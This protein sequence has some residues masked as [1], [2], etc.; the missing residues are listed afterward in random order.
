MKKSK[1]RRKGVRDWKE[2]RAFLRALYDVNSDKAL[3]QLIAGSWVKNNRDLAETVEKL[4]DTFRR[5]GS[6]N[7]SGER[8]R[9]FWREIMKDKKL[10]TPMPKLWTSSILDFVGFFKNCNGVTL[11]VQDMLIDHRVRLTAETTARLRERHRLPSEC[12]QI[13]GQYHLTAYAPLRFEGPHT[14]VASGHIQ[15]TQFYN[16]PE[17]A[18]AW[19][20]MVDS[21]NYPVYLDCSLALKALVESSIWRDAISG[22]AYDAAVTLGG[23]ASPEKDWDLATSLFDSLNGGQQSLTYVIN[24][25]SPYMLQQSVRI[26]NRRLKKSSADARI[27]VEYHWSDFLKLGSH[28]SRPEC[29]QIVWAIF[30][31]TIGNVSESAFFNSLSGPSYAGDLLIV[32]LDTVGRDSEKEFARRMAE[33][34]R[35][36]ELD[37]LLLLPLD[38]WTN[39]ASGREPVV[40]VSISL[41]RDGDSANRSDVRKSRTAVFSMQTPN[42][43]SPS[44]VLAHSTRYVQTE[45]IR[46]AAGHGWKYLGHASAPSGATFRQLLFRRA[47]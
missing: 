12:G 46:F 40:E 14:G 41:H 13:E 37:R 39:A 18:L 21:R 32:G 1:A 30:G 10:S 47:S 17:A 33:E 43:R 4:Y 34:Y 5:W 27:N 20:D 2:K 36:E 29:R 3:V 8:S 11:A 35:S 24:D 22:G 9:Q 44:T 45:F 26:L 7:P 42:G 6:S 38:G 23:G 16:M 31:G 15:S 28:F 19:A 25:I